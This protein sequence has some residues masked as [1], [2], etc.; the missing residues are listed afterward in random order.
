MKFGKLPKKSD[1]RTLKMSKYLTVDLPPSPASYDS[2]NEVYKETNLSDP[3]ILFPMDGNDLYGDCVVA[4]LAHAITVFRGMVAQQ[5][6]MNSRSVI[7]RYFTLTGGDD[8]GLNILDTLNYWRHKSVAGDEILAYVSLDLLNH[9]HV[10]QACLL[11]GGVFLGFIVQKDAIKD[12]DARKPWTPGP[13]LNSGH[14]VFVT[15][16]DEQGVNVLTWGNTQRGTWE[17]FDS[18]CDEAYALLPPEANLPGFSEGFDFATL[19]EDLKLV[20]N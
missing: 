16:Y 17:W 12:F 20:E 6:I 18:C 8:S 14:C 10:K 11:F 9:E 4:A 3:K 15:G 2:L 5:R 13:T 7:D 19:Q 1:F